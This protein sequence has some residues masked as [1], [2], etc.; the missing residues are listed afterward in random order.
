MMTDFLKWFMGTT[1]IYSTVD[2]ATCFVIVGTVIVGVWF[3]VSAIDTVAKILK[4]KF[5]S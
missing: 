3:G 2:V 1:P 5:A 4:K